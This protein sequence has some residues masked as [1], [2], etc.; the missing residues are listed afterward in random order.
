MLPGEL[1]HIPILMIVDALNDHDH[2]VRQGAES[3]IKSNLQSYFRILDPIL[4]RLITSTRE[5]EMVKYHLSTLCTILR[6]GGD[7]LRKACRTSTLA[8]SVH[9]GIVN[10]AQIGKSCMT[11]L[12]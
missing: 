8:S 5:Y 10:F 7:N 12:I 3:W 6:S 4:S 2:L 1:F 9:P 11:V